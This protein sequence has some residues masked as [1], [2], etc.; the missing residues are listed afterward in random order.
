LI[1]VRVHKK[2]LVAV[3]SAPKPV[4]KMNLAE[5]RPPIWQ[6]PDAP[7]I[8]ARL[9]GPCRSRISP[10]LSVE[11]LTADIALGSR[12]GLIT[13]NFKDAII[14]DHHLQSTALEAETTTGLLP[15]HDLNLT[16]FRF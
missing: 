16:F 1:V 8:K 9:R 2:R 11:T 3:D 15:W 14:F 4:L 12:I 7:A 5:N 13:S 10:S 6:L